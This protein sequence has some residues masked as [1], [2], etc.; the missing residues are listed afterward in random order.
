MSTPRHCAVT[1]EPT[2]GEGACECGACD[3]EPD[4]DQDGEAPDDVA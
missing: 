3:G 2:S 1:H 4:E